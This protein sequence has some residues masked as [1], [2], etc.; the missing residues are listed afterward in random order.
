LTNMHQHAE[1]QKQ[2]QHVRRNKIW[3][4]CSH[5]KVCLYGF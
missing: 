2:T 1:K 5:K 3:Y 4:G